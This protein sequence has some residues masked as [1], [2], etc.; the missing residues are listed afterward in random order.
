MRTTTACPKSPSVPDPQSPLPTRHG[1]LLRGDAE[2]LLGAESVAEALREGEWVQPWRGVLVPASLAEEPLTR[3]AAATL[4]VDER[5]VL[6]GATAVAL[7][8]CGP[9]P[10]EVHV[11]VPYGCELRTQS[12]LV[13]RNSWIRETDVDVLDGLRVHALDFAIAELLCTGPERQALDCLERALAGLGKRAERF[14]ALVGQR[15]ARRR[16]RRGTRRALGLLELA[17]VNPELVATAG[18]A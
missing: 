16:D 10:G 17:W 5:S 4:R 13:V 12:G 1:A 14:R 6:S 3:A 8:G 15:L 7:H 18:G 11:T 2:R 9:A